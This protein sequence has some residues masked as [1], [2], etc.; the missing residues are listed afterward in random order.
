MES[1]TSQMGGKRVGDL[2]AGDGFR[3]L[4]AQEARSAGHPDQ[5]R[6]SGRVDIGE[7]LWRSRV[8]CWRVTHAA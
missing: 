6:R 8:S 7:M 2:L 4:P 5:A 1:T 3:A